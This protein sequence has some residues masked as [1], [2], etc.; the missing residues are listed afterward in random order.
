MSREGKSG[1]DDSMS[2]PTEADILNKVDGYLQGTPRGRQESQDE[3]T[4]FAK[5]EGDGDVRESYYAG[6][7]NEDFQKALDQFRAR[8]KAGE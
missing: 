1:A 5:G 8:M 2:K 3:L 6:W 4:D 7:K